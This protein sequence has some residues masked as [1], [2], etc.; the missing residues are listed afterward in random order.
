MRKKISNEEISSLCLELSL[1]LRAG[2]GMGDAL[3]LLSE[4]ADDE[5]ISGLAVRVDDGAS[6]SMALRESEAFPA[7]VCGLVETGERTGRTEQALSA[8]AQ[9]YEDRARLRRRVQNALL[10]PAAML[11]L[12]VIVIGVLLIKVLPVFDSVYASLGSRLT[13][14]AGGLLSLGRWLEGVMPVLWVLLVLSAGAV[15]ACVL[16]P[17]LQS[18]VLGVWQRH[19]GDRGVSRK[20]NDARLAQS[21]AMGMAGGLPLEEALELAA[22]LMES[23]GKTRCLNCRSRLEQGESLSAALRDS[24]LLPLRCCRLLDLG[25]RGGAG[26]TAMD[27][28]ASD[29]MEEG[30]AALDALAGRVEPSLVLV[31]SLLVGL[32]LLSVMLPL[33][34]IMAAIG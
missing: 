24:D 17:P 23:G 13:G 8:L 18:K 33:M 1:L 7:Y 15:A 20:L 16:F 14:V 29:L 9:Y 11:L 5:V 12:M 28:I 34:N 32:I 22:G 3:T 30:E 21:L 31:C 27:K 2:V 4:E 26:D 25:Q 19:W 10:Y 6:L